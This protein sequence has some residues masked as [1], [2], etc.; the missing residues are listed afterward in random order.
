[1]K[2]MIKWALVAT[3]LLVLTACSQQTKEIYHPGYYQGA[4]H[5]AGT[6]QSAY[7]DANGNI[8]PAEQIA[9]YTQEGRW[10][11]PHVTSVEVNKR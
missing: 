4:Q 5:R 11:R 7:T 9:P 1:M 3:S 8:H 6:Y 2:Y 10:V